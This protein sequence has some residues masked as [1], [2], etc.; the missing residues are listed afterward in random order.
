MGLFNNFLGLKQTVENTL[1]PA[2]AFAAITIAAVAADGYLSDEEVEGIASMLGRMHLFKSYPQD[3]INR[4]FDWLLDLLNREGVG[5]LLA[6]AQ[7][8]LPTDLRETAFALAA[9]LTLAD[10]VLTEEEQVFLN[11]L[12][13]V[14][15]IPGDLAVKI[16]EV[17]LI[18][19]CG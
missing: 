16:I 6:I 8:A 19:N 11:Q 7:G 5:A 2:E 13:E 9:D 14:L 10:G 12:C 15:N 18:K 1:S 17:M 4:M 3:L